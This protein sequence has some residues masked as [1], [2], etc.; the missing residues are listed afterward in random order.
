MT[1]EALERMLKKAADETD[2]PDGEY[3][4]LAVNR[5]D[6]SLATGTVEVRTIDPPASS[7]SSGS[8]QFGGYSPAYARNW[9]RIFGKKDEGGGK[10]N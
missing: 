3:G 2:L 6:G 8:K 5:E 7:R 4:F 1:K 10:P 9:E